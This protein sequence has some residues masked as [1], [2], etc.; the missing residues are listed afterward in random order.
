MSPVS[1]L[2]E[3]IT[4]TTP[5]YAIYMPTLGC[6]WGVN[7]AAVLWQ[8]HG[9]SH[10][11]HGGFVDGMPQDIRSDIAVLAPLPSF[12]NTSMSLPKTFDS[13]SEEGGP[14]TIYR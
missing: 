11:G 5:C 1:T 2:S 14:R 8:S 4:R 9:A 3:I 7:G 6:F 13:L 12:G 10:L